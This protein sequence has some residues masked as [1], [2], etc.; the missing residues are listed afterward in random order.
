MCIHTCILL[1]NKKGDILAAVVEKQ[2]KTAS[3]VNKTPSHAL[4]ESVKKNLI[5][6]YGQES[7]EDYIEYPFIKYYKFH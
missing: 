5:A 6:Q 7:H 4:D 1:E 2:T 3:N